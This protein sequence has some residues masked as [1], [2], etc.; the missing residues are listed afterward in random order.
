MVRWGVREPKD[1][2]AFQRATA[3]KGRESTLVGESVQTTSQLAPS[4]LSLA[5]LHGS[6]V[7]I[8]RT[9]LMRST[10]R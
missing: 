7:R 5:E 4:W 6:R 10:L 8:G 9:G 1:R 3:W 2:E